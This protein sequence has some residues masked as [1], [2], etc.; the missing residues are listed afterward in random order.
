MASQRSAMATRCQASAAGSSPVS[1][2]RCTSIPHRSANA[3]TKLSGLSRSRVVR[4]MVHVPC[5]HQQLCS[6]ARGHDAWPGL[7][8]PERAGSRL[9][10]PHGLQH[11]R[12]P[13]NLLFDVAH[14]VVRQDG[15]AGLSRFAARTTARRPRSCAQSTPLSPLPRRGGLAQEPAAS[16]SVSASETAGSSA[17]SGFSAASLGAGGVQAFNPCTTWR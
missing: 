4:V 3:A 1:S 6:K 16:A 15:V 10:D 2:S 8:N 9:L 12:S 17:G 7:R 13:A 11:D 14:R 5:V